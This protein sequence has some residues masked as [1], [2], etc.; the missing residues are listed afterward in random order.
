MLPQPFL[1]HRPHGPRLN[2]GSEGCRVD[3]EH[4]VEAAQVEG[5][6]RPVPLEAGLDTADDA[7]AAAEWNHRG[8][9]VLAPG[10]DDLD[11]GLVARQCDQVRGIWE[12]AAEAADD[13][14]VALA[15]CPGDALVGVGREEVAESRRRPQPRLGNL[16]GI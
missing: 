1:Q 16:D 6:R 11:L 5:D 15:E 7:G 8:I 14:A 3:L 10:E 2:P 13:I 9:L 4:P 12:L